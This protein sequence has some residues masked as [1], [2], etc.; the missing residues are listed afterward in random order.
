MTVD[1]NARYRQLVEGM[2][3]GAII[4]SRTGDLLYA[5]RAF[6]DLVNEPI[7]H[8]RSTPLS[9]RVSERDLRRILTLPDREDNRHGVEIQLKAGANVRLSVRI[10]LVH[11]AGANLTFLLTDLTGRRAAA[12]ADEML[13]AIR[14]GRVDAIVIGDGQVRMLADV[15][16]PFRSLVERMRQGAAAVTADGEIV[17]VNERFASLVGLPQDGFVG[18]ALANFI[19]HA[20][21][22]VWREMLQSSDATYGE[23]LLRK[24][25]GGH[26]R[27]LVT[28][29][30]FDE[31]RLFLFTDMTERKRNEASDATSG[32][33]L[34]ILSQELASILEPVGRSLEKLRGSA[35]LEPELRAELEDV[36]RRAER[37]RA[38]V[39]D[40]QRINP[41]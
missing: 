3:Q 15:H 23:M 9:A 19:D 36:V 13:D 39:G 40:L 28:A 18:G 17:F 5:N 1:T 22:E 41:A 11:D 32:R 6:A 20:G 2:E 16:G 12:E 25:A 14:A 10:S 7:E 8:V 33:F 26:I 24:M 34:G 35:G 30:R 38:L 4:T 27:V 37:M 29:T 31:H 21:R